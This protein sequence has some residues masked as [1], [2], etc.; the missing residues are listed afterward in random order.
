M[1]D[2]DFIVVG[3]GSAGCVLAARLSE[4]PRTSVALIEAGADSRHPIIE[5]P[6]TWMQASND[7]RFT[8]GWTTEPEPHLN[9]RAEAM[10]RGKML[11]G[12]SALNGTMYI[13][14]AAADYDGWRDGGLAGWSYADVL[15]Y[16]KRA[17]SSW[18]GAGPNHGDNG[19]LH[20]SPM[21]PEPKL[22]AAF[23]ETGRRLGYDVI[24]DFNVAAPE[25]FGLPDCT[26]R[27]GRRHSTS[28]AYLDPAM[29][30]ANLAVHSEAHVTRVLIENDRAVGVE[31]RRGGTT[32]QL[33]CRREVILA[34]GAFGSPHILLLSGIG[35]A[36]HLQEVGIAPLVDLPGVGR[37][38]QDHPIAMTFWEASGPVTFD[39]ALRADRLALAAI[40]WRLFGTGPIGQSPMSIQGFVRS[41]AAQARPDLQFQIVHSSYLARPWFPGWRKGAGHHFSTGALLLDPDSRGSVELRSADPADAPRIRLN[42]LS[43]EEDRRRLR[44][45]IRFTRR[46][47]GTAPASDLVAAET[48]PGL[49]VASDDEIDAWLRATAISGAHQ[50][51]TCAMGTG[52]DAVLDAELRVRGVDGLRVVDASSMPKVVRGNTNAPVIMIAE[53]AADMIRGMPPLAPAA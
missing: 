2:A 17:E 8:W 38:L 11:G 53:K 27:K 39:N 19:P 32:H 31:Y 24:D 29:K 4:D 1:E 51:C 34:A 49:A 26:I 48:G 43:T 20:V 47:F 18:R 52:D 13:R 6:L 23:A 41:D 35:P 44:A 5:S 16:F 12:S 25:G 22:F 7:A 30:R 3:G 14:G 33:R 9:G 45:G 40:R 42:F 37:N 36:R 28:R 50:S 10:P 46:F 15:P 21:R